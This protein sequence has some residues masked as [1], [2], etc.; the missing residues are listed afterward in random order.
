MC[1]KEKKLSSS[2]DTSVFPFHEIQSQF[3]STANSINS[4]ISLAQSDST[5]YSSNIATM[6]AKQRTQIVRADSNGEESDKGMAYQAKELPSSTMS[7]SQKTHQTRFWDCS[8]G[9]RTL[10]FFRK[11]LTSAIFDRNRS[12]KVERKSLWRGKYLWRD[13]W[14]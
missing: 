1:S 9:R 5:F 14:S 7:S 8:C 13:P 12:R 2:E 11:N 4:N 3:Y 10:G 6:F